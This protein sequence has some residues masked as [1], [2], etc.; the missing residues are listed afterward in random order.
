[1]R[2]NYTEFKVYNFLYG[3]SKL[4]HLS[5]PDKILKL[6]RLTTAVKLI[7]ATSKSFRL[8]PDFRHDG[9]VNYQINIL[10]N[11]RRDFRKNIKPI[12]FEIYSRLCGIQAST[13]SHCSR[14]SVEFKH[15]PRHIAAEDHRTF[16]QRY[17]EFL[18][19]FR[20]PDGPIFLEICEESACNGIP[21]NYLSSNLVMPLSLFFSGA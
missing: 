18:D 8:Q 12:R 2:A 5:T 19:Y 11:L 16:G 21:N 10:K 13:T 6:Q 9:S 1:M 14:D 4:N 7:E 15:Q 17:Y 3:S 20:I